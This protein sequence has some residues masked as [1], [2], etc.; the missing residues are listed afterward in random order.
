MSLRINEMSLHTTEIGAY[1]TPYSE[2]TKT[3]VRTKNA[4]NKITNE[5]MNEQ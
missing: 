4:N 3:A 1:T 2:H 5:Q